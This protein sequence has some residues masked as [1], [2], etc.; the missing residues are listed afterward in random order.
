[1]TAAPN[2]ATGLNGPTKTARITVANTSSDGT[3][4]IVDVFTVGSGDVSANGVNVIR[5]SGKAT[6]TLS[7]ASR[8]ICYLWNP[9]TSTYDPYD[10]FLVPAATPSTTVAT[11]KGSIIFSDPTKDIPGLGIP[12]TYKFALSA[13]VVPSGGAIACTI[14]AA[15][16]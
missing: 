15:N 16:Y 2:F 10:E 13:T 4:T 14:E 8:V 12:N 5:V 1:M 11:G 3:G 7:T 9:V 6:G